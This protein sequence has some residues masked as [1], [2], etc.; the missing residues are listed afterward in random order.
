MQQDPREFAELISLNAEDL[1]I[2]E[3]EQRL[4][5]ATAAEDACWDFSCGTNTVNPK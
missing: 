4:E 1:D 2:E 5:L 3:L